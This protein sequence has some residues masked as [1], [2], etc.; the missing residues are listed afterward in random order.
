MLA[1]SVASRPEPLPALQGNWLERLEADA[2]S[3]A[4]VA[5][6]L[7]AREPRPVLVATHGSRDRAEWACGGWRL[8]VRAHAFVLC[9]QGSP[10]SGNLYGWASAAAL[11]A[12]VER[13]LVAL[14]RRFGAH[15]A[16]GTPV[17]AGFS[18]GAILAPPLLLES[19]TQF[20]TAV[21]AEGG[22]AS[23]ENAA[24]ARNYYRNGGRNLLIACGTAACFSRASHARPVLERAGL[25]VAVGGDASA[26]HNLNEPMQA[27]LRKTFSELLR[28]DRRWHL[29]QW[30]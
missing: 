19:G 21:F 6:P 20:A 10:V 14:Q 28:D 29:A 9:P 1:S 16:E 13:A 26:G 8:A 24:F 22:Y 5:L 17:Y 27:A 11:K 30:R 4:F 15:V 2:G 3:V 7:G 25:R 12:A 23:L 18:Q